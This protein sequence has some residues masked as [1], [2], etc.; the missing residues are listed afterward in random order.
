MIGGVLIA[1]GIVAIY[2]FRLNGAAGLMVDD[3]WYMM[4]ARALASGE[5]YRLVNSPTTPI[6]PLYPPGFPAILSLGFL[7]GDFPRN[8][9]LLKSV[10]MAAMAVTGW[11]TFIHL[12]RDR[13]VPRQVAACG[14]AAVTLTPALVFLATS[15][16]MSEPVFTLSQLCAVMLLHRSVNARPDTD[17]Q[18]LP[19][20]AGLVSVATVLIRTAG[21]GVLVA[22]AI[23]F[24]RERYWK[25]MTVFCVAAVIALAPWML[26][27]RANKATV[28]ARMAHRG[29]IVYEYGEQ[30][31]MRWAGA[32][33]SG[34]ITVADLP[35]RITTNL[36]DVFGRSIAGIVMPTVFRG[37]TESGEEVVSLGGVAGL[38]AAS[39]GGPRATII[40]SCLF[41]AIIIVGFIDAVR[42]RIT[43]VEILVP[44]SLAITLLWP[45]W[46]FRFVLPLTPYL[47]FYLLAGL[48]GLHAWLAPATPDP[49]R[50][51]RIAILVILGL[52][53][54]DHVG[55]ILHVRTASITQ[56]DEWLVH[57]GEVDA[58]L[59]WMSENLP[60]EVTV[61]S[62]NPAL[63][64]LRTG[65]P[66][67]TLDRVAEHWS[68]W[69]GR[70]VQFVACLLPA[71][72]PSESL[73]GYKV[74]YQSPGGLWIIEI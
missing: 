31:W 56:K 61:A 63:V 13:G 24:A 69:K 2:L 23:L 34:A 43:V 67:V 54:Y 16:V 60:D 7:A 44:V 14:A 72:L 36:I 55:Y 9:W 62:T 1:C 21:I 11:L 73:G 25:G 65:R 3:A 71:D 38:S 32:P 51:S 57:S 64:Y 52:H 45:F 40:L 70:G 59:A 49:W 48:R 18:L 37:Q 46:S 27:S 66:T 8:V 5:G 20:L 35:G 39:M 12:H 4:L 42:H 26:Y 53:V 41:T 19:A 68:V 50:I 17:T 29:S 30:F 47:V 22:G 6:L 10:S 15:T 28:E 74:L 33:T 58:A